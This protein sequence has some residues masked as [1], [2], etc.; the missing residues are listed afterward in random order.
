MQFAARTERIRTSHIREILKVAAN[1]AVISF[2]G[3]LPNPALFPVAEIARAAA[4]VFEREGQAALQYANSEGLPALREWISARYK[5]IHDLNIPPD[6]IL[7]TSGSQQA[8][9]LLG[10]TL[11][12]PG[13]PVIV[14]E[15]AYLGALQAFAM[16]EPRFHH[17]PLESDGVD[18]NALE[19]LPMIRGNPAG[20]DAYPSGTGDS[21]SRNR[22]GSPNSEP[23]FYTTPDFQ[24][25][26]GVTCS[27]EK[28]RR[29]A[30]LADRLTIIEDNPYG[31]LIYDDDSERPPLLRSLDDRVILL[32]SFSK[33]VSP[34]VRVG[35]VCAKR[36]LYDRLLIAR[37][38]ADLHTSNLTQMTIARYLADNDLDLHISALRKYYRANRDCMLTALSENFPAGAL[39]MIRP[40]GGMFLWCR[41]RDPISTDAFFH[42]ALH[43]NVLFVPGGAFYPDH[44]PAGDRYMRLN[45]SNADPES[46]RTGVERLARAYQKNYSK[47]LGGLTKDS[48]AG[49]ISGEIL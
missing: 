41:F 5:K 16:Y 27:T 9:D 33:I 35:W 43:E 28:R 45:F 12:D 10:K 29:L 20:D 37:Q 25:P 2:A 23:I 19:H 24:N 17:V 15:P 42:D 7:I 39:E 1:P 21:A 6:E 18:V 49:A 48:T 31:D 32:G 11:I 38:A 14:E 8:L 36:P 40:G 47:Q 30:G 3:G 26:A 46:I 13:R 4:D 34:G 44:D 22:S